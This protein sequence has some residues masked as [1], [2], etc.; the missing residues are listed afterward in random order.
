MEQV[1]ELGHEL[2]FP[3]EGGLRGGSFAPGQGLHAE[4]RI[5]GVG[6]GESGEVG[7]R[8]AVERSP[9][10]RDPPKVGPGSPA[11][12]GRLAESE[13]RMRIALGAQEVFH[14]A[15]ESHGDPP[16]SPGAR[17][18]RLAA[19]DLVERGPRN[20]GAVGQF[21]RAPALRIAKVTYALS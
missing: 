6:R 18:A 2:A 13:D 4:S 17:Q 20:L 7:G 14:G 8:G 15:L 5:F 1:V 10:G 9:L 21:V 11:G 16:E 19:L 12:M 3:N